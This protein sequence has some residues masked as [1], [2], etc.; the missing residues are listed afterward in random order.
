MFS[1]V[2]IFWIIWDSLYFIFSSHLPLFDRWMM[3]AHFCQKLPRPSPPSYP[4]PPTPPKKRC[5][6]IS[7]FSLSLLQGCQVC[8]S[9]HLTLRYRPRFEVENTAKNVFGFRRKKMLR[10]PWRKALLA[11]L[12]FWRIFI[13]SRLF[14]RLEIVSFHVPYLVVDAK[15]ACFQR[16]WRGGREAKR[17]SDN[18]KNFPEANLWT[19]EGGK[20]KVSKLFVAQISGKVW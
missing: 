7:F 9:P 11:T 13:F 17:R 14:L 19:K 5:W 2:H 15:A 3:P 20:E 18:F 16:L 8:N 4:P 10:P 12:S 1:Q 6:K